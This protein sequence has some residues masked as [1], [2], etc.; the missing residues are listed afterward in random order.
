MTKQEAF[1]EI[2]TLQDEYIDELIALMNNKSYDTMKM[3]N[4]TSPTGTGKT[5]M[6]SKLIN[7]FPDCY[8]I[9]TT[10]SKGQLHIQIRNSLQTDCKQNNFYVYGSADYKINSRFIIEISSITSIICHK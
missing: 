2:N 1:N 5:K 3:L 4:F 7:K 9:I 6:M 10:L 8:F